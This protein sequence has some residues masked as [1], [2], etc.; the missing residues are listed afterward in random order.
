MRGN[1]VEV[2]DQSDVVPSSILKE[3]AK[4]N[5]PN[6]QS[7][8]ESM[9]QPS[10][11]YA[12]MI[13]PFRSP[14]A[15]ETL[16]MTKQTPFS[17]F[18]LFFSF[19]LCETIAKNTNLK[20]SKEYS[21]TTKYQRLWHDTVASEIGAFVGIL[22]YMGYAQMPRITDYWNTNPQLAIHEMVI[23]AMGLK[24][25]EQLKRFFKVSNLY[26]DE[27]I[28]TRGSDWWKKLEPL[29]TNFRKASRKYWIP[30]SH[31]SVDEQLILFKGRSCH[32]MQ[33][34]TKAAGVGFKVYSLCQENY[35]FDFLFSSKV[36]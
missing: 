17:L 24:R 15:E 29:A 30:G 14:Q 34:P 31:L 3:Q 23:Q 35:L 1:E 20:A 18:S 8:I 2:P 16:I 26:E 28:D 21:R 7:I 25:W 6:V 22:L 9:P 12:P 5:K 27:K 36:S 10:S 13:V 11:K 32:T 19:N 33:I 4:K